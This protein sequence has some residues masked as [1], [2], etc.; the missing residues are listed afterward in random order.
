MQCVLDSIRSTDGSF[1]HSVS[2]SRPG[3]LQ[4]TV[5]SASVSNSLQGLHNFLAMRDLTKIGC[6]AD[7]CRHASC[8]FDC[9]FTFLAWYIDAG[10][11]NNILWCQSYPGCW[12]PW[13]L[14]SWTSPS[15]ARSST[16]GGR[17]ST[18]QRQQPCFLELAWLNFDRQNLMG[19]KGFAHQ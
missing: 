4:D 7:G 5:N 12:K 16:S 1:T 13:A 2:K 6:N 14:Q 11:Q 3:I 10:V 19:R 8:S 15:C 9:L 18:T 17:T